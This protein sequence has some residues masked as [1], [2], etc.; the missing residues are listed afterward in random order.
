MFERSKVICNLGWF[1]KNPRAEQTVPSESSGSKPTLT[2]LMAALNALES[3]RVS[4]QLS[5]FET[6]FEHPN[7]MTM[8]RR[9]L[10][11]AGMV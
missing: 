6:G 1:P 2:D 10:A 3:E 11:I 8:Y 9:V 7:T 4:A 5:G